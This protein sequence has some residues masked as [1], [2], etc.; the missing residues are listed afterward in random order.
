MKILPLVKDIKSDITSSGVRIKIAA[1]D[2]YSVGIRAAKIYKQ[3]DFHKCINITRSISNK[4]FSGTT[5]KELPYI[6]GALGM[7]IPLP[8]FSPLL[9]GLGFMAKY[10]T[11]GA[12]WLYDRQCDANHIDISG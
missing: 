4:V 5:V 8:L 7:L 10:Y 3:N 2:G 12:S 9:M 6:G 11:Q 1:A